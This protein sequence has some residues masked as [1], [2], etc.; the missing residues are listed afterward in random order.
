MIHSFSQRSFAHKN[1]HSL[2]KSYFSYVFDSFS[3]LSPFFMPKS[4]SLLSLFAPL[5]FCHVKWQRINPVPHD[6]KVTVSESLPSLRTKSDRER[7]APIADDKSATGPKSIHLVY[8]FLYSIHN[9]TGVESREGD[10]L[11][12]KCIYL[13]IYTNIYYPSFSTAYTI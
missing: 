3:L 4:E 9:I 5:L 1:E 12:T 13:Y 11:Q 7:F 8:Q 2:K 6:K 10:I